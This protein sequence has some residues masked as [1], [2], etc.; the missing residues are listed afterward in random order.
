[1]TSKQS[2]T[3]GTIFADPVPASLKFGDVESLL[4]ARGCERLPGKGS[5]LT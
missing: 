3:I 4:L 5:H 2:R 1:L